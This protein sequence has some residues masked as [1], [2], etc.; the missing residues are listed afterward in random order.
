MI[1]NNFN[2]YIILVILLFL[3]YIPEGIAQYKFDKTEVFE[4]QKMELN[5]GLLLDANQEREETR[6]KEWRQYEELTTGAAKFQV[7]SKLWNFLDYKQERVELN[8]EIGP[9][10]GKGN[11][12]DSSNIASIEADHNILG[13]RTFASARYASRFYYNNKNYTLVQ[14]NGWGRYDLYSQNSKGLSTDSD[15]VVTPIDTKT[16]EN[17]FRFNISGRAGWGIGRL[18]PMNN[19]M[20]AEY[21]LQKYYPNT[22]FSQIE[23]SNL[24]HQIANIKNE[25]NISTGHITEN[26]TEYLL[27]YLNQ[28]MIQKPV[29]ALETDWIFGEFEPRLNGSRVE[30][31]PFF[32]Y[33]NLEPDFFYGA[34]FLYNNAKYCNLKWNRNFSAGINYNA[35]KKQDWILAEINLGWSYF[36][37]L[38]SQFDFGIR[39]VPGLALNNSDDV[40]FNNGIIPFVG[41]FTQ[42]STNNRIDLKLA[43]R[44]SQDEKIMMP[45]LEF[46]VSIYRSRY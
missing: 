27:E 4:F 25:R 44:F 36:I 16:T 42:L 22:N 45:G 43:Y 29:A 20:I 9:F 26:E 14:I 15:N 32:N 2:V 40:K 30:F 11:W 24:A 41:Y 3:A 23:I 38:K 13:L 8:F 34:Y 12:I 35:Y 6:T 31:G 28:K 1:K 46:S 39:Y 7:K 10:G 17:K 18:N 5:W 37:K 33:Y 19:F 21:L